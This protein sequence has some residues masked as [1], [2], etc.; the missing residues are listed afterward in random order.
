MWKNFLGKKTYVVL[1]AYALVIV[2]MC[3]CSSGDELYSLRKSGQLE[4]ASGVEGLAGAET[5]GSG[6][7]T[8][9]GMTEEDD[10]VIY[11]H[12]CGAVLSPGVVEI[13]AGSRAQAAVDAAGGF[14]EEADK[15]YVN[16]AAPI[17]DGEQLYIPTK[18]EAK[19]LKRDQAAGE[20]GI[21]NLNTADI[22]HLCTLPGIG[23]SRAQDII[24]YRQKNGAFTDTEQIMQVPGIK[25]STYEKIKNLITVS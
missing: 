4:E 3:G 17:G 7:R 19:E 11:V 25:A 22:S 18:E 6:D 5:L 16:L 15:T 2:P 24:T 12:V 13:S 10:A 14:T 23:E 21:V 8:D 20:R 9:E 1:L